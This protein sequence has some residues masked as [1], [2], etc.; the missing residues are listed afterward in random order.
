MKI[1][2]TIYAIPITDS[3]RIDCRLKVMVQGSYLVPPGVGGQPVLNKAGKQGDDI[4]V[5]IFARGQKWL[6]AFLFPR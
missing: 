4:I 2:M 3:D 5:T 6:R 1:C